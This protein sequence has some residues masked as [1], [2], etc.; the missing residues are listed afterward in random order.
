[1]NYIWINSSFWNVI[2]SMLKAFAVNVAFNI[3]VPTNTSRL[4][5]VKDPKVPTISYLIVKC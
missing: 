2:I 3:F 5:K 4:R 1:M